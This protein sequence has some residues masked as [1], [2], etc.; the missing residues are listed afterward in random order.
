MNQGETYL[1][2]VGDDTDAAHLRLAQD[3]RRDDL[4]HDALPAEPRQVCGALLAGVADE[5]GG[6]R[7]PASCGRT[8]IRAGKVTHGCE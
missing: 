6:R 1:A 8:P 3:A 5:K 7:R 4:Q 2:V